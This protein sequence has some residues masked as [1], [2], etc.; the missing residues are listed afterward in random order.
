MRL[1]ENYLGK[2]PAEG[3]N[4]RFDLVEVVFPAEGK[5]RPAIQHFENAF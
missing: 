1:A 5:G 4:L 2:N 3:L